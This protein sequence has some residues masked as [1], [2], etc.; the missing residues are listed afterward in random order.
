MCF[1]NDMIVGKIKKKYIIIYIFLCLGGHSEAI[2]GP[3]EGAR[4]AFY[5][6]IRE[7]AK[8][9]RT[10]WRAK[11]LSAKQSGNFGG[12]S[13]AEGPTDDHSSTGAAGVK[14]F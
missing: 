14:I 10:A 3:A 13:P 12:P 4:T 7:T 2:P 1:L 5:G 6:E 9:N 11:S 8:E